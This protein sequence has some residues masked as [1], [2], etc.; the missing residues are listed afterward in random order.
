MS[1]KLDPRRTALV[2]IDMQQAFQK[3]VPG[4]DRVARAT[5]ALIRG[6]EAM[7]IP[8]LVTEQYP[9]GLGRTVPEVSD[10]EHCRPVAA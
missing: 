1:Y 10:E 6:A 4:F 2:V 3:A 5:A 7:G 8:I 9:K